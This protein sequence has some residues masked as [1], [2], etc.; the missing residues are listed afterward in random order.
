MFATTSSIF[1]LTVK[2]FPKK[3]GLV[4]VSKGVRWT[5]EKWDEKV[6]KL[7]NAFIASGVEKG[8]VVSTYLFN[9]AELATT[10]FACGKIGAILNPINF[11]L[12]SEELTYIF[13]DSSPKIVLFEKALK[14]EIDSVYKKFP[15]T[16]FWY[17][18]KDTPHYA[19]QYYDRTRK[20]STSKPT[21]NVSENDIYAIMYTSGT[22]GRPKGVMHRH[23][24]MAEQSLICLSYLKLSE[25]DRGLA[26]APMFHCAELHCCFLPR[27]QA[28]ATSVIVHH[29]DPKQVLQ[30]IQDE[31]VS[32]MFGA[33]TMWNMMLQEELDQYDLSSM[34]LGLYGAAPMPPALVRACKEK[35]GTELIQAYGM[36]EM[37][38]AITFLN[39][40]D[41]IRKTGSVG[42]P[43]FNHEIRVVKTKEDGPSNPNDSLPP[44]EIGEIIVKGPCMMIGYYNRPDATKD[45]LHKGWY[46][47]GDLGYFDEDGYLYVCD[48]V[49]DM[50][51]SGGENIYPREVE[52]VL[53]DHEGI[54]DVAVLGEPDLQWGEKVVAFIVKK[55]E[56]LTDEELEEFCKSSKQLANY[57][58]PRKY[59]FVDQLPRN[60]SGKIQKYI[61]RK[62]VQEQ[63]K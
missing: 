42:R 53:Y 20:A 46:H 7:A 55:E 45:S 2:N 13:T 31:K 11:R 5:Y 27:V 4:D 33:P 10:F 61:L 3:E 38:P 54:L 51:I 57:K 15:N 44:R 60:A 14:S 59:V 24:D 35:L 12:K 63:M 6:N 58:R 22:T 62:K 21:A 48:R 52:D 30:I 28:G 25:Y 56:S 19:V 49:D 8:D 50:I 16:S 47:S 18:D 9:T 36:T 29:F 32:V 34:R 26:T 43:C 37:G 1:E 23:R 40:H 39:E 17:V 41:Q